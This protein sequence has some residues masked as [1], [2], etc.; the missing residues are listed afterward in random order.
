VYKEFFLHGEYEVTRA[1]IEGHLN[2]VK[3]RGFTRTI[4][5]PLAGIGYRQAF[6]DRAAA[7]IV[8]LYNFDDSLYSLYPNPV[9]RFSFLFNLGR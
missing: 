4:T 6:S 2:K 1:S 5:S 7:D 3:D 9:I 8:V